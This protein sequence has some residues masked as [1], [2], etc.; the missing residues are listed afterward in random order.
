MPCVAILFIYFVIKYANGVICSFWCIFYAI[1][2]AQ[3]NKKLQKNQYDLIILNIEADQ[4][5]I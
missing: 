1:L 3:I 5:N 4:N 2:K